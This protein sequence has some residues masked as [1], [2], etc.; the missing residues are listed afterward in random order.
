MNSSSHRHLK[1][2]TDCT[3]EDRKEAAN[4]S[5]LQR[6]TQKSEQETGVDG[7][8]HGAV[9]AATI[10]VWSCLMVGSCSSFLRV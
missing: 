2:E 5:M 7:M 8:A 9:G 4:E 6:R 1:V 3:R 10:N